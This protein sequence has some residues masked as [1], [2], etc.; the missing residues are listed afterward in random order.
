MRV[1]V[2]EKIEYITSGENPLSSDVIFIKGDKATWIFDVGANDEAFNA[3]EELVS[4]EAS[5]RDVNIVISHFHRD[6][7]GNLMRILSIPEPKNSINFY[8][9]KYTK[10]RSNVGNIV[11]EDLFFDDG[12]R[13]HIFPMPSTH[14]KGCLCLEADDEAVFIGD[15]MYPAYKTVEDLTGTDMN[16]SVDKFDSRNEYRKQ[17][18]VYNVQHLK[19]Q[20]EILKAIDAKKVYLSHEKSPLVRKAI[21]VKFLESVYDKR[22]QGNPYILQ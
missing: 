17:H 15:S 6:H 16:S 3:I 4:D 12:V 21:I 5:N 11:E 7:M 19:D 9:S 8:V 22:E 1:N 2:S 10:K 18:K 13:I 20:I 14:S